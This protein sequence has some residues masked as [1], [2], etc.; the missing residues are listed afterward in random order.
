MGA[1]WQPIGLNSIG[2]GLEKVDDEGQ[3]QNQARGNPGPFFWPVPLPIYQ[4]LE[5]PILPVDVQNLV[6]AK[7]RRA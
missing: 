6:D 4:V 2:V 3:V 5:S 7:S 1:S